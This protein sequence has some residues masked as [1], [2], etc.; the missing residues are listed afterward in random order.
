EFVLTPG[1]EVKV[2]Q[3]LEGTEGY[4]AGRYEELLFRAAGELLSPF[5]LGQVRL[6]EFYRRNGAK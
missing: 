4:D 3:F 5:D 2:A 6:G 1:K